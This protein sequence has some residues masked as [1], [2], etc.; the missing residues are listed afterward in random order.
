MSHNCP[1][2]DKSFKSERGMKSHHKQKHN[3]SIVGVDVKCPKC[4]EV[5]TLNPSDAKRRKTDLCHSCW[6]KESSGRERISVECS[7]CGKSRKK[8]PNE[9]SSASTDLCIECYR[10]YMSE[11]SSEE[12]PSYKG[13]PVEVSCPRCGEIREVPCWYSERIEG[14]CR[15]CR[16]KILGENPY[17]PG[18]QRIEVEETGHIVRSGWEAEVDKI[19]FSSEFDY[20]YEP[21]SVDLG[22]TTYTPD[23]VVENCIVIEVKGA[24]FPRSEEIAKEVMKGS[25]FDGL[26]MV[27]GSELPSDIHIPWEQREKLA[28]RIQETLHG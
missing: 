19:L 24:V 18:Q 21:L 22:D 5:R 9:L 1:S 27:V 23:F 13:G 12:H 11:R 26:Y 16:N 20:E 14:F 3:R 4:S 17:I 10:E 6:A 2:C 7:K 25:F 28:L 15:K 8:Q